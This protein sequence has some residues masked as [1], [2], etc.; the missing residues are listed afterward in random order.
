VGV[1]VSCILAYKLNQANKKHEKNDQELRDSFNTPSRTKASSMDV[2]RNLEDFKRKKEEELQRKNSQ[3]QEELHQ[4]QQQILEEKRIVTELTQEKSRLEALLEETR[5]SL[6]QTASKSSVEKDQQNTES[7]RQIAE[8]DRKIQELNTSVSE[9]RERIR[10]ISEKAERLEHFIAHLPNEE[11][12]AP[13]TSLE[14]LE[15]GNTRE[16]AERA[17]QEL[18]P[19]ISYYQLSKDIDNSF[20]AINLQQRL[21]EKVK[22]YRQ[23]ELY[24]QELNPLI[25]G[26]NRFAKKY[27]FPMFEKFASTDGISVAESI[28]NMHIL[29][30]N[31]E[32]YF[33]LLSYW[34]NRNVFQEATFENFYEKYLDRLE[35]HFEILACFMC[36]PKLNNDPNLHE[37]SKSKF[38]QDVR[39]NIEVLRQGLTFVVQTTM[40]SDS[41]ER[42]QQ[43]LTFLQN[44]QESSGIELCFNYVKGDPDNIRNFLQL[45]ITFLDGYV[46]TEKS[47]LVHFA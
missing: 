11:G 16:L 40:N 4:T 28:Q 8:K 34:H 15:Q 44:P 20:K 38:I 18:Q 24:L 14:S 43:L 13:E 3:F 47:S 37:E 1:G 12:G 36:N 7:K 33:N 35:S 31:T 26:H 9:A 6:L 25:E 17:L 21:E 27:L 46:I 32:A 2:E 5:F 30:V 41:L 39:G 45:L 42:A 19:L 22:D 23:Q 29:H 10:E